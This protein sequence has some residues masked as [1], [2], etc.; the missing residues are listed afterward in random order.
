MADQPTPKPTVNKPLSW[1][2]LFLGGVGWPATSHPGR[3]FGRVNCKVQISS[4]TTEN[5]VR[6]ISPYAPKNLTASLVSPENWL[7]PS[8]KGNVVEIKNPPT[9]DVQL[10]TVSFR[11][12]LSKKNRFSNHQSFPEI[13]KAVRK[14]QKKESNCCF[15]MAFFSSAR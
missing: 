5:E 6:I 11:E 15:M 12:Y 13:R 9:F 7:K 3:S 1:G 14:Q 2:R 8:Q 10:E 4:T